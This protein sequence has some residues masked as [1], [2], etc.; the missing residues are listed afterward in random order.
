[1]PIRTLIDARY[2]LNRLI[3]L[4]INTNSTSDLETPILNFQVGLRTSKSSCNKTLVPR[5]TSLAPVIRAKD[6]ENID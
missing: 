5:K 1:M 4:L 2:D 3:L 6:D